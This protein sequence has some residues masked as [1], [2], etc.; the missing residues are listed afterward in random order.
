MVQDAYD[1]T[2]MF[3]VWFWPAITPPLSLFPVPLCCHDVKLRWK[4]DWRS[5]AL[6]P[7]YR[8]SSVTGLIPS[9]RASKPQTAKSVKV[10][11]TCFSLVASDAK[12]NIRDYHGKTAA[13][14]WSGCTDIFNKP[15][16]QSGE[17][18]LKEIL[19]NAYFLIFIQLYHLYHIIRIGDNSVLQI[20]LIHVMWFNKSSVLISEGW[21]TTWFKP[22][23]FKFKLQIIT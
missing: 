11:L 15:D 14:Y 13:H 3:L 4:W 6:W 20:R 5:E 21:L 8:W 18:F 7:T 19:P 12:T 17:F 1:V 22:V 16:A 10:V 23:E 9:L 2:V